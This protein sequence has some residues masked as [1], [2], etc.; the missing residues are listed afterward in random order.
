[1]DMANDVAK[2]GKIRYYEPNHIVQDKLYGEKKIGEDGKPYLYSEAY[3]IPFDSDDYCISVDLIVDVPK[4]IGDAETEGKTHKITLVQKGESI[5]FFG[6]TDGFMT[7]TPGSTTYYDVLNSDLGGTQESLGI[8][9]IHITYNSY[10]Y[11]QVTIRFTDIRGAALMMPHEET[12]RRQRIND[13]GE[14]EQYDVTVENFFAALFSFPYPD[15]KLRV[16]GFYGKMVEYCLVVEDFRSAFNPQTGNFDATV[17]F[18]GKMYGVYT[19]IPMTYLMMAPYCKYGGKNNLTI[20]QNKN[21]KMPDGTPMPTLLELKEKVLKAQTEM[22]KDM[23]Y[24]KV[25]EYTAA[26]K[27]LSALKNIKSGYQKLISFLKNRYQDTKTHGVILGQSFYEDLYFFKTED[28]KCEYLYQ[29]DE[30]LSLTRSMYNLITDYN[31]SDYAT[32]KLLY[33]GNL[34]EGGSKIGEGISFPSIIVKKENASDKSPSGIYLTF[35]DIKDY[36][37]E[38]QITG[39]KSGYFQYWI[40]HLWD[41]GSQTPLENLVI[42]SNLVGKVIN[43]M[44]HRQNIGEEVKFAALFCGHFIESLKKAESETVKTIS[45]LRNEIDNEYGTRIEQLIGFKPS[46][47]N[48]F[49]IVLTHLHTFIEI[50][51]SFLDNVTGVNTRKLSEYGLSFDETDIPD[52]GGKFTDT[53]LPPFPAIINKLTNEYA[54]PTGIVRGIMEETNLIDALFD[55]SFLML[56]ELDRVNKEMEDLRDETVDFIPTCISDLVNINNPYEYVFDSNES[57]IMVDWIMTFLGIRTTIYSIVE[58]NSRFTNEDFGKCEAFNFWRVNK[59]LSKETINKIKSP[60]FNITNY[61]NFLLGTDLKGKYISDGKPC[62]TYKNKNGEMQTNLLSSNN[63]SVGLPYNTNY[64]GSIGRDGGGFKTFL[65]DMDDSRCPE[66]SMSTDYR[67]YG[68][69]YYIQLIDTDILKTWNDKIM[70]EDIKDAIDDDKRS[71]II[72]LFLTPTKDIFTEGLIK[73][74]DKITEKKDFF[75]TR[76]ENRKKNKK[77]MKDE[78]FTHLSTFYNDGIKD[79]YSLYCISTTENDKRKPIFF[80]NNLTPEQ[81]LLSIPYNFKTISDVILNGRTCLTMPYVTQL[82]LGLCITKCKN[83]KLQAFI[84][85]NISDKDDK[86]NL[87]KI[88]YFLLLKDDK[89]MDLSRIS[90]ESFN[91][92]GE[93]T[94]NITEIQNEYKVDYLGL[95]EMYN[96]WATGKHPGSFQ[97]LKNQYTFEDEQKKSKFDRLI[98]CCRICSQQIGGTSSI[99]SYQEFH[100]VLNDEFKWVGKK[101]PDTSNDFTERYNSVRFFSKGVEE[102]LLIG[103]N[104]E[105][106]AYKYLNDLFKNYSLLTIPHSRLKGKVYEKSSNFTAVFSA[107][108]KKLLELYGATN[109]ETGEEVNYNEITSVNVNDDSK[110]SMY[111]TLK[112]LNDKHFSNVHNEREKY[113]VD[114]ELKKGEKDTEWDRFHFIDTFYNQIGENLIVNVESLANTIDR[115]LTNNETG[116]GE[117]IINSQMSLYSFLAKICQDNNMMLLSLPVFNGSFNGKD[118]EDNLADMFRPIPYDEASKT[119]MSGPS[120]VCFYPHQPSKHLDIP[121]GQFKNDGFSICDTMNDNLHYEDIG[122]TANFLGPTSIPDLYPDDY[123]PYTHMTIPAFGVEYG[124]QNQSIFKNVNVN[125]DNPMVTEYSVGAQFNLAQGKQT[126]QKT[127]SFNGQNLFD[128]YSNHSYTCNVEMMGC[129]QIMPLMYFQLNNIPMFRGAYQIINVEHDITPGNMTTSFKGV[130]INKNKIP[131]ATNCINLNPILQ[132]GDKSTIYDT[133]KSTKKKKPEFIGTLTSG[134]AGGNGMDIIPHDVNYNFEKCTTDLGKW[135]NVEPEMKAH[136]NGSGKESFNDTNP[137]LRKMIYAICTEMKRNE[138][139]VKITSMTRS[140]DHYSPNG[141]S[142]H[143]IGKYIDDTWVFNGSSR[144][145][146]LTGLDGNHVEKKYSEMGCAVDMHGML[147]NGAIDTVNASIPLFHLIATRFTENIRQLIWET[148]TG[149]STSENNISNCV[150]LASYGERGVN[151]SDKTEIFV[152]S[153]A[154]KWK[155]VVADNAGDISKAPSNLPPMFI[156][157]LYD[158]SKSGKLDKVTLNNFTKAN[159]D[160]NKLTTTLLGQWCEQLKV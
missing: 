136:L 87:I 58:D 157:T 29:N 103:F 116:T 160:T 24:N 13:L 148:K 1:M 112:N 84:E 145:E 88:L 106:E 26:Q 10:F 30:F 124:V 133:A 66:Y 143:A 152:A 76:Q 71:N 33:L 72:S 96:H 128:V 14:K 52:R 77:D 95:S 140:N 74:S 107:F 73:Y 4:R 122:D 151:G 43:Y 142:D 16:K 111:L 46:I 155:A 50:Y 105:F 49:A 132:N 90:S 89:T 85:N 121:N 114:L 64:P 93:I 100:K 70:T 79:G 80:T 156:R 92:V 118:T 34:N 37:K 2:Y 159:I 60:D 51:A 44:L 67:K 102:T 45:T 3:N 61:L 126:E 56:D 7:D 19:D 154:D 38:T 134:D 55:G 68:L 41:D 17:K 42:Y 11:P 62:Y 138:M 82:F 123:D 98:E 31:N 101:N 127:L 131:M 53:D 15:F 158:M 144:R 129:S 75:I 104:P 125:M 35:T 94:E 139:G 91:L 99:E 39:E 146:Q 113:V 115:I 78:N 36:P 117:G 27:R 137:E 5:S 48:I 97:Y 57:N 28:G 47:A 130:R 109:P 147:S 119:V 6:G 150:H 63:N 54:Y 120:Y 149:S 21:F 25:I 40:E 86:K 108:K 18:I 23:S 135:I 9:N 12:Y 83:G 22:S 110:L 153:G 59:R 8:T 141:T 20:W 69:S 32:T 65:A 81:F